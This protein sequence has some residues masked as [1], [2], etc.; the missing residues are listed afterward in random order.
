MDL[1][2]L[3]KFRNVSQLSMAG[4]KKVNTDVLSRNGGACEKYDSNVWHATY[5]PE[6]RAQEALALCIQ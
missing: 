2:S 1:H 5:S 3:R 4:V 6:C